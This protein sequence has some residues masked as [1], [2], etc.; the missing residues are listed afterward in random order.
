MVD[1]LGLR[2]QF[3]GELIGPDDGRYTTT[4]PVWS[5]MVDRRPALIAR[6][7]GED[8][9]VAALRFAREADLAVA[10]RGGGH[11]VAGNAICD[12]GVVIDLGALKG[13]GVDPERATAT[14][15]PGVLL[16][17]LDRA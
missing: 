12:G 4:R 1:F 2:D 9:V 7:T 3:A 10:V 8:D 5:G 17:E 14:M 15:Q 6:C 11:N 13:I 16:G